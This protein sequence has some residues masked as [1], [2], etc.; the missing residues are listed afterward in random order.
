MAEKLHQSHFKVII[1]GGSIT[2]LTLA[3]ALSRMK[4]DFLVLETRDVISPCLGAASMIP[5][6]T[7]YAWQENG[8]LLSK[9]DTLN[10]VQDRHGYP[11]GWIDRGQLLQILLNHIYEKEKILLRKRFVK[12]E[13][14][15]E[16]IIAHCSDGSSF[17]GDII[18]G[19]DGVHSS[20]R[21]D[22]WQHMKDDRLEEILDTDE[23]AMTAEYSCVYGV[24]KAVAGIEDG[25]THRTMGRGFSFLL[26]PGTKNHFYWY[27]TVKMDKQYRSPHIPR[28][29]KSEIE[30]HISRYLEQEVAP[31]I[32]LKS[33]YDNTTYCHYAPLEEAT[34]EHW[35]WR[36]VVCLGDSIHKANDSY[37]GP[38]R[39]YCHRKCRVIGK[40]PG[41]YD[42]IT[43][44]FTPLG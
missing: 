34:Y 2:G 30:A 22:M 42:E 21:Q 33:I 38:W 4:I 23:T 13:H 43:I 18:I 35:T 7:L 12:A 1:V 44:C 3:N 19:A 32:R 17:K 39:Q 14:C 8:R 9:C 40:L 41:F 20:V 6:G 5:N 26:T 25:V 28:Y 29:N 31:N 10:V 16:G 27:L 24:S 37:F 11:A 36:Q 15:A